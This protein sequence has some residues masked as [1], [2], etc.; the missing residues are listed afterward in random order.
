VALLAAGCAALTTAC[1]NLWPIA[2]LENGRIPERAMTKISP[3]CRVLDEIAPALFALLA[4]AN[5][6]GVGLQPETSSFLPPG[7]Q[8]PPRIESCY[9]SFEMQEWWRDYYCSIDKCGNAAVPGTS[10]HG[11]GRAVDFQDQLG[12][13]TFQSPGYL[14][15]AEHA[16]E[17]GFY[18]PASVQ[19]GGANEEA[20]HWE[21]D[22]A[23]Q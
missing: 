15:L 22:I 9:R 13:L 8:G 4:A 18:Q 7:V 3:Q 20:W 2:T 17:Y 16:D 5:A 19:Q 14:W 21:H 10:K 23:G 6:E 11:I 12:E 1:M